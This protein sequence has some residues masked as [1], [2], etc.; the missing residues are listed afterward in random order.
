MKK[1]ELQG[2]VNIKE[3]KKG[4]RHESLMERS[5]KERNRHRQ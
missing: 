3:I 2:G 1:K 5:T 4:G